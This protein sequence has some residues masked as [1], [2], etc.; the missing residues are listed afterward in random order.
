[1]KNEI[2]KKQFLFLLFLCYHYEIIILKKKMKKLFFSI[3][4]L[5]ALALPGTTIWA[6]EGIPA[7]TVQQAESH[8]HEESAITS[9]FL[10]KIEELFQNKSLISFIYILGI[11]FLL[12]LFHPLQPGHGKSILLAYL[13]EK[14][15]SAKDELIFISTMTF[16]H[17][18]DLILLAIVLKVFLFQI[19]SHE[20][21]HWL[22][23]G[24]AVILLLMALYYLGKNL[25]KKKEKTDDHCH[26][27]KCETHSK[28]KGPILAFIAGITP[29][30]IGWSIM[31]ILFNLNEDKWI[32]PSVVIFALGVWLS[33]FIMSKIITSSRN[34]FEKKIQSISKIT[35][36]MSPL[37]LLIVAIFLLLN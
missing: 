31:I 32:I 35:N 12:G 29:C 21:L 27:C 37:I 13:I 11:I 28:T 2:I 30:A 23:K 24:T 6:A 16:S 7:E 14:K 34:F 33:L 9:G 15:R 17:V 22:Q 18:F 25:I 3:L 8:D 36:I 5:S 10:D 4:I 20:I 26:K 1:M 19:D